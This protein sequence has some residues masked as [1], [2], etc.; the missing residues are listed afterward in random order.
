MAYKPHPLKQLFHTSRRSAAK[1]WLSIM[2]AVQI[3]ITG[4]QG[5][6]NT[7]SAL[8]H[9]L[10][11]LAATVRTDLNL[12]TVYNVPITA[13]KTR[14]ATR[15][16]I[17]ELGIDHIGEMD[18]HLGIV[19]PKIAIVTG[20]SPVHTDA[21]HLGSFQ[22]LIR[23]KGKLVQSLPENGTAILNGDNPDVRKMACRTKARTVFYGT[24]P[25]NDIVSSDISINLSGTGFT[26][27]DRVFEKG[28][29]FSVQV[30][31]VGRH[32]AYTLMAAYAVYRTLGYADTQ[33]F[34]RLASGLKPLAGRMSV[35]P[36]PLGATLLNDSLRAN[37]A[38]VTSG[39]ETVSQISTPG[40][41]IAVL[42]EMGE[43]ENPGQEHEKIGRL[44]A[45]LDL[46]YVVGIGPLHQH[47]VQGA[48]AGGFPENRIALA[49]DV[50]EAA[51]KLKTVIRKHDLLYV[52]GSLLRHVERVLMLLEGKQVVCEAVT[53]PFY[54]HCPEC[55]YLM[56]GYPPKS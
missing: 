40:R 22:N 11:S 7:S 26:V 47:T 9:I 6:T 53:C 19:R 42:A 41:K 38:S 51:A 24:G 14:P 5:K 32:N 12:D 3:A 28:N 54:H 17:F 46:D 56:T 35:E 39:L 55:P 30:P 2:P 10:S 20:V 36:G 1:A 52:K 44:I 29:R 25:E 15:F 23:E 27:T 50:K 18:L 45:E 43:L 13:L 16:C 48:R 4:S 34:A 21:E 37:P 31:L 49:R 8:Y 33:R